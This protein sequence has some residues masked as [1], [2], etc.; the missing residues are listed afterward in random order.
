MSI[1]HTVVLLPGLGNTSAQTMA[2]K[3]ALQEIAPVLTPEISVGDSEPV[4]LEDPALSVL[5]VISAANTDQVVLVGHG[6]GSMVALHIAATHGERV[7]ALMLSTN[8]RLQTIMVRSIFYGVLSLLPAT[9][10][11]QLGGKPADV[12]A[13]FDQVRPVDFKPLAERVRAPAL[14][15]VGERDVANRGPSAALAKSLPLGN[16]RVMPQA[17]A[18]WQAQHP[19]LLAEL[20]VE[21]VSGGA[22]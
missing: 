21:F 16:L 12:A 15:V 7:A 11:Q 9:V 10:V 18:G 5:A 1:A 19:E 17:G 6:W 13:L 8:A 20:L 4:I 14:V 3:A 22:L 2:Q